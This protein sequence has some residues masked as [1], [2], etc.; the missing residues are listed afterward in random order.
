MLVSKS[1]A[2]FFFQSF[3]AN[4]IHH[5]VAR[6]TAELISSQSPIFLFQSLFL[7]LMRS[8]SDSTRE[9][10]RNGSQIPNSQLHEHEGLL[11]KRIQVSHVSEFFSSQA[12]LIGL[13]LMSKACYNPQS[14]VK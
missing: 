2:F 14:A 6:H 12:D 9:I 1:S 5:P 11:S 7:R 8:T 4:F 10:P 3:H 13:R